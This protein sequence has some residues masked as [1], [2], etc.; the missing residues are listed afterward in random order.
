MTEIPTAWL[1]DGI[2]H[3]KASK[4]SYWAH[5]LGRMTLKP[6]L[7]HTPLITPTFLALRA[8]D[9]AVQQYP[10]QNN[11]TTKE[12]VKTKTWSAH[13][14]KPS[15]IDND[16]IIVYFH[17]G[18]F[19]SCGFGT[20]R[21]FVETL[22]VKNRCK[23][24]A[25]GYRQFPEVLFE[26]TLEDSSQALSWLMEQGV[27]ADKIIIAGDSAGGGL[28]VRVAADMAKKGLAPK[29][30]ISLSGWLDFTIPLDEY[31]KI[32]REDAYIP[33]ERIVDVVKKI[34]G[35]TPKAHHSSISYIDE[36]FPPILLIC[37]SHEILRIDS[38]RAFRKS[39]E[40]GVKVELHYFS[41]GVHAFPIALSLFPESIEA[42]ELISTFIRGL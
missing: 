15:V 23:V 10:Q 27:D 37:G 32:A 22:A 41:G 4:Q 20:H 39:K 24:L 19:I 7:R 17:G 30:V 3:S 28:A 35:E 11:L 8:I 13:L 21:R 34:L 16:N 26:Q 1:P 36:N 5:A 33:A 40:K 18:A 9:F 6:L 14:I 29:A 25:I 12:V 38:E 2:F 42:L 31:K